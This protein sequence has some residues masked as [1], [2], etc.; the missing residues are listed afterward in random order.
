MPPE[1]G[2]GIFV[3][4]FPSQ[5]G[6]VSRIDAQQYAHLSNSGFFE[7]IAAAP[8]T[9]LL[10]QIDAAINSG[11]S[12]GPTLDREGRVLG[13]AS[14]GLEGAQNVGYVIPAS[15]IH[16]FIDSVMKSGHWSGVAELGASYRTM[17]NNALRNY[18]GMRDGSTGVQ[19]T[20]VAPMGALADIICEGDVL[21][22]LNGKPISN[23]GK[24]IFD[25]TDIHLPIHYF[26]TRM[27]VGEEA[28]L[29]VFSAATQREFTK[30]VY[31]RQLPPLLPRYHGVDSH[32][33]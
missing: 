29:T 12:G 16:L 14:S 31:F 28:T 10:L 11:S 22:K 32:P 17:E 3:L 15:I 19:I 7:H 25:D 9:I 23:E 21:L 18:I 4:L 33:S 20:G 13:V 6:V 8:G 30:S 1:K 5:Q 27:T 26:I 24:I 2:R